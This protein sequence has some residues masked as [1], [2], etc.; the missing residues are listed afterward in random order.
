[1]HWVNAALLVG[2]A[3]FDYPGRGYVLFGLLLFLP[4][5]D[6]RWTPP[7]LPRSRKNY[8]GWT[9]LLTVTAI[10]LTWRPL[11]AEFALST[12]LMAALPEE[13]FFRAY[14]M[15][16]LGMGWHANLVSSLLFSVVHGLT[17]GWMTALLVFIP[18]LFYGWLYQKTRDLILLVLVHMLSNLVY[19]AFLRQYL[20]MISGTG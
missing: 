14:F 10:L 17:W 9:G 16:Q 20:T 11:H 4:L 7:A 18:S 19:V 2:A 8:L 12:L 1:L 15:M 13:W 6:R 3:V 5:L